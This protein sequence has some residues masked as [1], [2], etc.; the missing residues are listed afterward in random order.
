ML[1]K[2]APQL[3]PC[4]PYIKL[5]G[6]YDRAMGHEKAQETRDDATLV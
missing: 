6:V 4:R 5:K 2:F 1:E 3:E